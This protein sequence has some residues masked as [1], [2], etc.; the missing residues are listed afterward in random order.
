M[1][2][3]GAVAFLLSADAGFVTGAVVPVDGGCAASGP[4]PEAREV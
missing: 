2:V 3:A 4:D 1:P